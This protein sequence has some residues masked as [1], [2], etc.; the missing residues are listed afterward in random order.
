[1]QDSSVCTWPTS[2][3]TILAPTIV[4]LVDSRYYSDVTNLLEINTFTLVHFCSLSGLSS[5]IVSR[6]VSSLKMMNPCCALF[7][8]PLCSIY[9]SFSSSVICPQKV[10]SHLLRQNFSRN[11]S[12]TVRCFVIRS[13]KVSDALQSGHIHKGAFSASLVTT[14][15]T[16]HARSDVQAF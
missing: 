13:Y 9:T 10:R 12:S 3:R 7:S 2:N 5:K 14:L 1:M 15:C 6:S 16:L 8:A 4:T 11:Y